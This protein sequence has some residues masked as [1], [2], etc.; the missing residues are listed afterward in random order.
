MGGG[1]VQGCRAERGRVG[2]GRNY[3]RRASGNQGTP[4]WSTNSVPVSSHTA[5][6]PD[7]WVPLIQYC[8]S[9]A[10]AV[11][12]P[13]LPA[14]QACRMKAVAAVMRVGLVGKPTDT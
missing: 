1:R 14:L 5:H 13:L 3:C 4:G 9:L 12:L 2:L 10:P 8:S 11:Q 7:S 6:P